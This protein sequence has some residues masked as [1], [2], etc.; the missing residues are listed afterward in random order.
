MTAEK[1]EGYHDKWIVYGK[2]DGFQYFTAKELTV[3]PGG[4]ATIKDKGAY[5]AIVV[6][7][8]G[9]ANKLRLSCPKLLRFNELSEDEFFATEKAAHEG[10]VFKNSSTTEPLV[11]LRY[12]GPEVNPEAPA[13]GAYR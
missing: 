9:S 11:L 6:Q 4:E 1:G 5:S 2:V 13:M 10:I 7:G 8:E 3:E 12:F